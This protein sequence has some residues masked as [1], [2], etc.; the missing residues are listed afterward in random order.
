MAPNQHPP[1]WKGCS[2]PLPLSPVEARFRPWCPTPRGPHCPSPPTR[3]ALAAQ[4]RSCPQTWSCQSELQQQPSDNS[5]NSKVIQTE[6][7]CRCY[8]ASCRDKPGPLDPIRGAPPP[9]ASASTPRP[10]TGLLQGLPDWGRLQPLTELCP[11]NQLGAAGGAW[12]PLGLR[13][14]PP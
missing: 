12:G 5:I 8:I 13:L 4:R 7:C 3:P 2:P 9:S 14:H 11:G 6:L 10:S 1:A